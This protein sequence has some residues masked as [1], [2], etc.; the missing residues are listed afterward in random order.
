MKTIYN[1]PTNTSA[2]AVLATFIPRSFILV[3]FVSLLIYILRTFIKIA[4]SG[5]HISLEYAQKASQAEF[6]LSILR[7]ETD[8]ITQQEKL[9]IYSALF[10][11]VDTGL[12]KNATDGNELETMIFSMLSKDKE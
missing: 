6:Y 8:E 7:N 9:L 1:I 11:K 5:K 2:E 10:S 4:T 12:I 3:A